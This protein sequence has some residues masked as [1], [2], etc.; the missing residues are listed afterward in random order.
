MKVKLSFSL[1]VLLI[2]FLSVGMIAASENI[3]QNT[4]SQLTLDD[5]AEN[6]SKNSPAPDLSVS[7]SVDDE[8]CIV[9]ED[10]TW[11][12]SV[13]NKGATA[14]DARVYLHFHGDLEYVSHHADAGSYNP[15]TRIWDIGNL[16]KGDI[17]HLNVM[18]K[19]LSSG[20]LECRAFAYTLILDEFSLNGHDYAKSNGITI[21]NYTSKM[22][23]S[24]HQSHYLSSRQSNYRSVSKSFS[25][26]V[27]QAKTEM[28]PVGNPIFLIVISLVICCFGFKKH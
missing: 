17:K 7:V 15:D 10:V 2:V 13:G 3:T 18:T 24:Y 20:P 1:V 26:P 9:G 22:D 14:V 28:K 16:V 25:N 4:D 23:D 11:A 8:Y 27:A 6:Y 19:V 5:N 12:I 21:Q